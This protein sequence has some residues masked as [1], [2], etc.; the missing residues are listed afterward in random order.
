MA[1]RVLVKFLE[2]VQARAVRDIAI[3]FWEEFVQH[4]MLQDE[5]VYGEWD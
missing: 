2:S 1:R 4:W 3:N 5:G